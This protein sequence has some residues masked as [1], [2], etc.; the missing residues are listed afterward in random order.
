MYRTFLLFFLPTIFSRICEYRSPTKKY[1]EYQLQM[2]RIF[3]KISRRFVQYSSICETDLKHFESIVG[4]DGVKTKEIEDFTRDWTRQFNGR[5]SVVLLPTTTEQVSQLLAHCSKRKL[6]VVPQAGNTG[7]VGGS[8][9]VNDEIVLSVRRINKN[10]SFVDGILKADAG[11]V[12]QDLD[13]RLAHLGYM[14]PFDLGAKGTC[15]IGGNIATCAG[16]IRLLRYGSLHAHLLGL[17]VVLPDESGTVLNLGSAI[18]KDNSAF[19]TPHLFLGSEGQL[20][21]ITSVTMTAVPKPL[22]VNSAMLAVESFDKCRKVLKLAKKM[23]SEILSSFEFIDEHAM[24]AVETKLNLKSV[25]SSKVP[26]SILLETSGSSEAHDREN[27]TKFL[28]ECMDRDLVTDGILAESAADAQKMWQLR[29]GAPLSVARDGYLWKHDVSLP[30][31]H[32]YELSEEMRRRCGRRVERIITFGH[33][34]DGNSHLNITSKEYDPELHSI[35]YPY[36]YQWVV[37]HGGSISAEHGVGQVKLPYAH[38]GKQPEEVA[39][40]KRLKTLFDPNHI[41]NPHKFHK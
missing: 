19:H 2:L 28:E 13:D 37:D 5:G 39:L 11:F 27:V 4:K 7:L 38:F 25:F 9:P 3:P 41:L 21:I 10:F 20:G 34:G 36:L 8:I 6:A 26:F 15:L 33:L 16:G 40:G 23:L 17:T 14:M 32:F 24:E 12:L 35:L 18:R 31:E 29:E 30:L 22:S 1:K